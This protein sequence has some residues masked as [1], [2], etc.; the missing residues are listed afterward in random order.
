MQSHAIAS[1][2]S[3]QIPGENLNSKGISEPQS[4]PG[5]LKKPIPENQK[6]DSENL[7]EGNTDVQPQHPGSVRGVQQRL[8]EKLYKPDRVSGL[9]AA[10]KKIHGEVH[11]GFVAAFT[12]KQRG[13][14]KHF[15]KACPEGQAAAVLE[16][17]LRNWLS[18]TEAAE[19]AAGI[20][21]SPDKPDV[22]F[23]LK[24]V[25]TAVNEHLE[26]TQPA[27]KKWQLK[28]PLKPD[29]GKPAVQSI[30]GPPDPDDEFDEAT[31]E[32]ASKAE[33]MAMLGI[34]PPPPD[35]AAEPGKKGDPDES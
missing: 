27:A 2:R 4:S 16:T 25:G 32:P 34:E 28:Q 35:T 15:I 17:C 6:S 24:H 13:Q 7:K 18:F 8:A 3:K 11:G 5:I 23:L 19:A 33:V 12:A 26:A 10:W 31:Y 20:K 29:L 14:L 21:S 30:A 9:E 22:G 1:C